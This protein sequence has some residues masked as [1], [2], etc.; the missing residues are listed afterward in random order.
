MLSLIRQQRIGIIYSFFSVFPSCQ[1]L[2]L[3]LC[4]RDKSVVNRDQFNWIILSHFITGN[5]P[6]ITSSKSDRNPPANESHLSSNRNDLT[7]GCIPAEEAFRK[8]VTYSHTVFAAL[9]VFN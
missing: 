5:G 8:Q 4:S 6:S 2:K 7:Q 3:R 9:G 1:F